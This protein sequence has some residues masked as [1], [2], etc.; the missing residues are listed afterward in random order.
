[1][2]DFSLAPLPD[3]ATVHLMG[4][5]E[6]RWQSGAPQ[7]PG[8]YWVSGY[9]RPVAKSKVPKGAVWSGPIPQP[10][11]ASLLRDNGYWWARYKSGK[12]EIVLVVENG[13]AWY[14]YDG[15]LCEEA[16][17]WTFLKQVSK[18]LEVAQ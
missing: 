8:F 6:M 12:P 7:E 4:T 10:P 3:S 17:M 18:P 16:D 1:M 14:C 9:G 15:G 5:Y 11:P 13:A 2:H